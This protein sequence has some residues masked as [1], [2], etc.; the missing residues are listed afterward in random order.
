M[1]GAWSDE[2]QN[3]D[4]ALGRA[5]AQVFHAGRIGKGGEFLVEQLKEAGVQLV[6]KR[7]TAKEHHKKSK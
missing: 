5:G 4:P 1:S 3:P 6:E 2:V 7:E